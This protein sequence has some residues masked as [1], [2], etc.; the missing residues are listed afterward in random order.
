[1]T[2]WRGAWWIRIN[3]ESSMHSAK[4]RRRIWRAARRAAEQA[5][6]GDRVQE[7]Q[8]RTEEVE[9]EKWERRRIETQKRQCNEGTLHLVLHLPANTTTA[10]SAARTFPQCS[11][12]NCSISA[13][14]GTPDGYRLHG[15]LYLG[16]TALDREKKSR[17]HNSFSY[18]D[19]TVTVD[20]EIL[21]NILHSNVDIE[22]PTDANGTVALKEYAPSWKDTV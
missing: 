16:I 18:T 1:M 3:D 15:H 6:D 19:A 8:R 4:G 10:A 12:P 17:S 14:F 9:G 20:N 11:D 22:R 5:R 21:R 13:L 2:W 7:T